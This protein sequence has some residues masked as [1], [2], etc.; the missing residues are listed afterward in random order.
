MSNTLLQP[1]AFLAL[2]YGGI[3]TGIAYDIFRMIR[4]IFPYRFVGALCDALF[5]LCAAAVFVLALLYAAGGE[6]RAYLVI[7]Y[8]FGFLVQQWSL[9]RVFFR[10][11]H[12]ILPH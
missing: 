7:G 2:A 5:L 11:F 4:R 9:S 3:V 10:L 8:L 1:A 6:L 12:S